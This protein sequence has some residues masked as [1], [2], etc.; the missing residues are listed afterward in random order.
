MMDAEDMI[1]VEEARARILDVVQRLDTEERRLQEALGQV[2][3]EDVVSPLTIPPLDNTSMDGYAVVAADTQGATPDSPVSLRVTGQVAAGYIYEGLVERGTA[4]RIM[5]GAPVPA[6][7]DAIVPFEETDEPPGRSFGTFAKPTETVAIFKAAR[8]GANVREAGEDI[9]AGE[10]VLQAG[11][12]LGAAQ[13]GV[14]ASLGRPTVKVYRRPVVAI[15]STGDELLEVGEE[16]EPG[17]IYDANSYSVAALV[18]EAGGIPLRLGIARDTV[19]DLTA[20]LH[21][22]LD[23][24][25]IV[26]SAGVSRGDYDVVKDVLVREGQIDFWTVRMRPGKPLAFGTFRAGDRVIPHIGLP[27]NPVSSMVTFELFG[28]PSIFKMMGKTGWERPSLR[29]VVEERVVNSDGRR[30][31]ARAIVRER[32]GRLTATL[33]G[34][35]GSGILT[36]MALANALV[37]CPEDVPALEAGQ[38]ADAIMLGP[39]IS[40]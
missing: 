18:S 13:I 17:R 11:V 30:F 2:L 14:L 8:P 1:S 19:D 29:V 39:V 23:A 40:A 10:I 25:L 35:Q 24:D 20:K 21:E 28:R 9:R 16:H 33:T 7:A 4:V 27:G 15:L 3:A 31:L 38:E 32:D 6:G 12:Q 26:T 22:A 37:V 5:T 36:S 34:P